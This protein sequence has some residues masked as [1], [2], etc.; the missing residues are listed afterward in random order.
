MAKLETIKATIAI[1]A[2]S[3]RALVEALTDIALNANM[4]I[5]QDA[6]VSTSLAIEAE[7]ADDLREALGAITS[8]IDGSDDVECKVSAPGS[9]WHG[10]RLDPTQM[11]RYINSGELF[12]D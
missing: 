10:R 4:T 6:T 5:V 1:K 11:E 3:M 7:D 8:A 9:I 2:D 12:K